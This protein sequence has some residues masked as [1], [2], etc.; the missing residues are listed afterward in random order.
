MKLH[1]SPRSPFVRKVMIVC[2]EI[3]LVDRLSLV[4]TMVAMKAVN[5]ELLSDNPL[6]KLPTLV[7]DDGTPLY[8]SVV[9]CEYLDALHQGPRLFPT[10]PKTKWMALRRHA[11]GDGL[12][13]LLI[14]WRNERE[15]EHPAG[16]FLEA[17]HTKFEAT[18]DHLEQDA[19]GLAATPFG[20]GHIAIGC[21]LSYIDFRFSD[22]DWRRDRS[23]IAAWHAS[24]SQR[25]SVR[26][27]EAREG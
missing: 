14:L 26:A 19:E 7:L 6:S 5:K 21:G 27:T 10:E 25:P 1:W 8:D 4:R 15:R 9:I 3:G 17:F 18:L 2:H 11:L 13:D 12:L 16:A 22:V 23:R 24:F 20:I